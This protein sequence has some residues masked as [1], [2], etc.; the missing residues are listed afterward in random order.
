MHS[1]CKIVQKGVY[2]SKKQVKTSINCINCTNLDV[3][4]AT[5]EMY[6]L[7]YEDR[8]IILKKGQKCPKWCPLKNKEITK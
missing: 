2:M 6:C 5:D 4:W 1:P 8:E 3:N 7:V